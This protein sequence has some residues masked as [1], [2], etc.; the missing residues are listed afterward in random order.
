MSESLATRLR[1]AGFISEAEEVRATQIR[2]INA[3]IG[4][5]LS[6]Q[7]LLDR[8]AAIKARA[9]DDPSLDW[10]VAMCDGVT[11]TVTTSASP[12]QGGA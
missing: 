4:I 3:L 2:T 1:D 9:L 7:A 10:L 12:K 8:L 6:R 11:P 5:R